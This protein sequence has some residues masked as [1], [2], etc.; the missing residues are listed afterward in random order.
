MPERPRLINGIF[1]GDH[2]RRGFCLCRGICPFAGSACYGS[3]R[4]GALDRVITGHT[5]DFLKAKEVVLIR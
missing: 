1:H 5:K 3:D 4:Q 2:H